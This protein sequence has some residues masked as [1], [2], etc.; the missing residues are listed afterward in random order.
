MAITL[1]L[2]DLF[3]LCSRFRSFGAATADQVDALVGCSPDDPALALRAVEFL[4]EVE[5]LSTTKDAD[6][7]K[8]LTVAAD[9]LEK[10]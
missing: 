7:S 1:S 4:K 10:C 5:R 9:Y 3:D 6:L 8:S 2:T